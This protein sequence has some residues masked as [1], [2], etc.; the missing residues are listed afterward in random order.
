MRCSRR[1]APSLREI[2]GDRP[3]GNEHGVRWAHAGRRAASSSPVPNVDGAP[4]PHGKEELTAVGK[5]NGNQRVLLPRLDSVRGIDAC[6]DIEDTS[7]AS[8]RRGTARSCMPS[9]AAPGGPSPPLAFLSNVPD[10]EVLEV[11]PDGSLIY[12][13]GTDSG[14]EGRVNVY[15][16]RQPRRH[17]PCREN[18]TCATVVPNAAAAPSCRVGG[19][20]RHRPDDGLI[21]VSFLTSA[22]AS[23]GARQRA[24]RAR[25]R[26]FRARG[27]RHVCLRGVDQSGR[28]A[29]H[30]LG[31]AASG[32][33]AAR[34]GAVP[35]AGESPAS[36][37]RN[38]APNA[39]T[40]GPHRARAGPTAFAPRRPQVAQH[41]RRR[42]IVS[43][44]GPGPHGPFAPA[45][46]AWAAPVCL[47]TRA[48]PCASAAR[49]GRA[50]PQLRASRA[51]S[52]FVGGGRL[53]RLTRRA[54]RRS[55][56]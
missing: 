7:A 45:R 31:E 6:N 56:W 22:G 35:H 49:P 52:R 15:K 46:R 23:R 5:A 13:N 25:H 1:W 42:C 3:K 17:R 19:R 9:S 55:V 44:R 32:K 24:A 48:R 30:V 39:S 16:S 51:T 50:R 54:A 40:G 47:D 38:P 12:A 21:L 28:S 34:Q 53:R 18:I 37:A 36:R 4:L 43:R 10:G 33:S 20:Q 11:H 14:T 26:H 27:P 2:I 29:A 41:G 8:P